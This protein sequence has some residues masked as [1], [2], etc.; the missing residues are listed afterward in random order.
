MHIPLHKCEDKRIERETEKEIDQF[1]QI[2]Q[3]KDGMMCRRTYQDF[4]DTLVNDSLL[5]TTILVMTSPQSQKLLEEQ[6]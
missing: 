2:L 3:S 5:Q 4:R 6:F 1:H